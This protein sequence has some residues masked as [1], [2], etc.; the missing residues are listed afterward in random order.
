MNKNPMPEMGKPIFIIARNS[1]SEKIQVARENGFL[2]ELVYYAANGIMVMSLEYTDDKMTKV[3]I[4]KGMKESDEPDAKSLAF[5][6]NLMQTDRDVYSLFVNESDAQAIARQMN[7][8]Q[9]KICKGLVDA[10][11]KCF[12]EYEPIIALCTP[13]GK[14]K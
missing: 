3:L 11:T 5:E 4:N 13:G 12:H 1:M 6:Y 7:E 14:G 9:R 10:V 2:N 8:A